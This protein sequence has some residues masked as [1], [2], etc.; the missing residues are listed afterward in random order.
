MDQFSV[1]NEIKKCRKGLNTNFAK[2]SNNK[3]RVI[4]NES[5][6]EITAYYFSCPIYRDIDNKIQTLN[7]Q[8]MDEIY[9]FNGTNARV[10]IGEKC[11]IKNKSGKIEFIGLNFSSAYKTIKPDILGNNREALKIGENKDEIFIFPTFNGIA[12]QFTTESSEVTKKFT[13]CTDKRF[14]LMGNGRYAAL[15]AENHHPFITVSA[16][17]VSMDRGKSFQPLYCY[18][19]END[20]GYDLI[21]KSACDCI[22]SKRTY[23][24]TLDLYA[25]KSIFDTTV[26]R[27][28]PDMNNSYG[29][30]AYIGESCF[31]EE[32]WLYTRIDAAQ[33]LD[34]R[35][36]SVVKAELYAKIYGGESNVKVVRM[37]TP[38][39]SF[40][41]TWNTK[42][43]TGELV[44]QAKIKGDFLVADITKVIRKMLR[45]SGEPD[46]GVVFMPDNDGKKQSAIIVA[47][48]DNYF[49]PQILEIKLLTN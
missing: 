39:C 21:I 41:N 16:L 12:V 49:T 4:C 17:G 43:E 30:V 18:L 46:A 6:N 1:I 28:N 22:C 9:V 3:F 40:G 19:K 32:Q 27:A 25:P 33:L 24:F 34:L 42:A 8:K 2:I 7:F 48:G 26:E 11:V 45:Q 35:Y 44:S 14:F 15:M 20:R 31:F 23:I 10:E 13:L 29:S 47:T 36:F 5:E 37:N 38:W